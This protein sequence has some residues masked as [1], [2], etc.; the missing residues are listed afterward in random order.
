VA[1]ATYRPPID[2]GPFRK[3]RLPLRPEPNGYYSIYYCD[4][5]K[6]HVTRRKSCQTTAYS[7][8]QAVYHE[9]CDDC[10]IAVQTAGPVAPSRPT[11]D[12]LCER[13]IDHARRAGK[14]DSNR[15][16][17]VAPR[18]VFG[19]YYKD[20][21]VADPQLLQNYASAR[22]MVRKSGH[23]TEW[24]IRRELGAL[25]RVLNW[26]VE[27]KLITG[28]LPGFKK[29]IP[30]PGASRDKFLDWDQR[31]WFWDQAM[32]WGR[33]VHAHPVR[34]AQAPKIALFVALALETAARRG[35]ILELTWDRV[36]FTT[37]RIAYKVPGKTYRIKQ[38]PDP[39]PISQR[40]R[41]VLEEAYQRAPKDPSGKALGKV[42][43]A[44]I[45]DSFCVFTKAI[46]MAWV[47]PHVLRHTWA[48]LAAMAGK[49]MPDI[50]EVM[51]DSITMV[52]RHYR[53]L[54]PG[55]LEGVMNIEAPVRPAL[56]VVA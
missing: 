36:N 13:W 34:Q 50:S 28:E 10:W 12:Q 31:A 19:S 48:S 37:G 38:R 44:D 54:S 8:A 18:K 2:I 33:Q 23:A 39:L 4:A 51:A 29:V 45:R 21:L 46:G 26:A 40:L 43:D 17:L 49:S 6:G 1:T 27:Q 15:Y 32:T 30:P 47:T 24:T 7:E 41:P 42:I 20:D 35:A 9:F 3:I 14:H 52:M 16:V 25:Q 53:H 56:K 55:H 11:I 5:A 22:F